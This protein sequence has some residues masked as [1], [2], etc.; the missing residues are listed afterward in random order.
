MAPQQLG[1][2]YQQALDMG[3]SPA[4]ALNFAQN[5]MAGRAN[6]RPTAR[7]AG[8]NDRFRADFEA[9]YGGSPR[10]RQ[11]PEPPRTRDARPTDYGYDRSIY[12]R[13]DYERPTYEHPTYDRPTYDRPTYD[14]PTYDRP[15]YDRPTLGNDRFRD[16][17]AA[18]HGG[19]P[20]ERQ[21]PEPPRA[22][23][24]RPEYTDSFFGGSST[25]IGGQYTRD[26]Y[27]TESVRQPFNTPRPQR[28]PQY[29]STSYGP[30]GTSPT[31]TSYGIPDYG[32][33]EQQRG[34]HRRPPP[35][36]YGPRRNDR[37]RTPP[38]NSDYVFKPKT[39][40]Y[41]VLGVSRSATSDEI[42]K[43]YRKL[44][45]KH[46]PDRVPPAEH[47]RATMRMA[48][49]N[50]AHDVLK[51]PKQRRKYDQTGEIYSDD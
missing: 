44:S 13:F 32:Y 30:S 38:P 27:P 26:T 7:H 25:Q 16:A 12:D 47:D 42:K 35:P 17:F 36:N 2:Y 3:Y 6:D 40:L 29:P 31:A 5:A 11:R 43:A 22:R 21:R 51:D 50:Q 1:A 19:G 41:T 45:M 4:D 28:R 10:E 23:D 8:G 39:N 24:T 9:M 34:D 33:A 15:T 18:L 14:R 48:E 46:H 20:R 49:I 37:P